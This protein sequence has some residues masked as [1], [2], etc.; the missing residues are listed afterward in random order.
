[1]AETAIKDFKPLASLQSLGVLVLKSNSLNDISFLTK[2]NSVE[3]L[4]LRDN[5]IEDLGPLHQ[6]SRLR[7]LFLAGNPFTAI[8]PLTQL[9]ALRWLDL[10]H[11]Q[12]TSLWPLYHAPKLT[13][14]TVGEK[15]VT[16]AKSN[17]EVQIVL[18]HLQAKGVLLNGTDKIGSVFQQYPSRVK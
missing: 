18:D 15:G 13:D 12:V 4:D 9:P 11:T 1:L 8:T 10:R 17:K 7:K 5:E 16:I 14:L 6:L 3:W 2:L